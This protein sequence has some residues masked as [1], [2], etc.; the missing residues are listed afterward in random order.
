MA[1]L[2]RVLRQAS[3]AA[4]AEAA[5]SC[6]TAELQSLIGDREAHLRPGALKPGERQFS[7]AGAFLVTPDRRFNMLVAGVG[8]PP[9]QRRLSV[10][11]AHGHPGRVVRERQPILL[12]NTDEHA[13]FRQYLKTARMGSSVYAPFFWRGELLGQ[14][15]VASQARHTYGPGDLAVATAF[16]AA[17]GPLWVAAGGPAFLQGAYPPHPSEAGIPAQPEGG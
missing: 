9:E 17:A 15:L 4:N 3:E 11:I 10:P 1:A 6:L 8:F 14:L 5:L 7:V 13:D 12:A 2:A 16:A